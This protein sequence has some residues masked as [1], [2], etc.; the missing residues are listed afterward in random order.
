MKSR[1]SIG[2]LLPPGL[3][4]ELEAAADEEHR[5]PG[6]LMR[7]ASHALL[8]GAADAAVHGC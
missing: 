2:T 4:D 3:L 7:E 6:E 1:Q 8:G 5:E